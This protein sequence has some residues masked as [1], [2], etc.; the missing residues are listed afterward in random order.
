[1]LMNKLLLVVA[2]S[3]LSLATTV[4]S[5]AATA[6]SSDSKMAKA[7]K[8]MKEAALWGPRKIGQ[9]AKALS[10]KTKKAFHKGK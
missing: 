2:L 3:M 4:P 5:F 9:G 1:M 7:G 8:A 10:E 6:S